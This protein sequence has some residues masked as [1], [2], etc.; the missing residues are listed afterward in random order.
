[1]LSTRHRCKWWAERGELYRE[2]EECLLRDHAMGLTRCHTAITAR[3]LGF[4]IPIIE[5]KTPVNCYF[6]FMEFDSGVLLM[7]RA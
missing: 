7:S 3:L 5:N 4:A 6:Q 2:A 1:M